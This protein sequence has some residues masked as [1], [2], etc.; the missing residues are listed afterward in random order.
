LAWLV[1]GAIEGDGVATGAAGGV[2]GGGNWGAGSSATG[3]SA[4]DNAA[5]SGDS[6]AGSGADGGADSTA[7]WPGTSNTSP[8]RDSQSNPSSAAPEFEAEGSAIGSAPEL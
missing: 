7:D 4:M 1:L 6:A 5:P 8:S 2:G 3:G